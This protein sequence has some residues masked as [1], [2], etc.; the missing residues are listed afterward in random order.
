MVKI[1]PA[2]IVP[3]L[4]RYDLLEN[5]LNKINYPIENILII[6][7]GNAYTTERENVKVLN[8]PSNFGMS[9]S[10]NLAI[11]CFPYAKYWLFASAD[12]EWSDTALKEIDEAMKDDIIL[13]TND[14]YGC[15]AVGEKVI[16]QV[17]LFDEYFYPI[18]YED[19]DFHDRV[20][21]EMGKEHI[22]QMEIK[23]APSQ[24]SQTIN[25]NSSFMNKNHQTFVSNEKYYEYKKANNYEPKPWSLSRRRE[26][27]WL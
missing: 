19:N 18:Y 20:E 14:A 13:L 7:N 6:D 15:F 8:M 27:E 11:K 16:E 25:S 24:G 21:R 26:H 23:T 1:I 17:G 12:T 5:M 9:A 4:N 2:L 10:W 22:V 3:V